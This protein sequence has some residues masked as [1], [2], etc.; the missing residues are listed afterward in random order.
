MSRGNVRYR[1]DYI[2]A[3]TRPPDLAEKVAVSGRSSRDKYGRLQQMEAKGP[4]ERVA[5]EAKKRFTV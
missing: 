5:T 4:R 2:D 1:V 3:T